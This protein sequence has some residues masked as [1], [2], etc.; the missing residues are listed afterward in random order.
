MHE[1][2][3]QPGLRFGP[4]AS[5]EFDRFDPWAA[6]RLESR[7]A[8]L[9]KPLGRDKSR[10][11]RP[12]EGKEDGQRRD[13]RPPYERGSKYLGRRDLRRRSRGLRARRR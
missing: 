12:D 1:P 2:R 6:E 10:G 8:G 7:N 11:R 3:R 9:S 5:R 13:P 4:V